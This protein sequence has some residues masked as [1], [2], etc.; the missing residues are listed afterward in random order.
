MVQEQHLRRCSAF[1]VDELGVA[2]RSEVPHRVFFT[3]GKE[4]LKER[5]KGLKDVGERLQQ[6]RLAEF[7]RLE[8]LL[9]DCLSSTLVATKY[10]SHTS[11]GRT[12][13]AN[14]IKEFYNLLQ[15]GAALELSLIHI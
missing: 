1:L 4:A 12:I 8:R 6:G 10:C 5:V 15:A 7:R 3:S 9:A 14:V 2:G 13:C 11:M